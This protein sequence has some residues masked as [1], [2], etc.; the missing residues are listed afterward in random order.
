M[1]LH[2]QLVSGDH[3]PQWAVIRPFNLWQMVAFVHTLG[4]RL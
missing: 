3:D 1:I 4:K 2:R